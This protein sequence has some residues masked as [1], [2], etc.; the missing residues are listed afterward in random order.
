MVEAHFEHWDWLLFRDYLRRHA[1]VVLEYAE[2]KRE[3]ARQHPRDRVAYA[4]GKTSFVV[5]V[6][7]RARAE[8]GLQ[9]RAGEDA[10]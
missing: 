5:S 4:A 8:L 9:A 2:L 1:E 3:L 6:T 10:C 7:R